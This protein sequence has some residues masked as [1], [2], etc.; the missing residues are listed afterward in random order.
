MKKKKTLLGLVLLVAVLMLGIGYAAVTADVLNIKGTANAGPDDANFV[1]AFDT[2]QEV[3]YE[4]SEGINANATVSGAYTDETN[5]TITVDK[6]TAKGEA[7]T[8]IYTVKNSSPDLKATLAATAEVDNTTYF[9]VEAV[10]TDTELAAGDSTTVKVTVTLDKT[11]ISDTEIA[12]PANV[13][14]KLTASP[15]AGA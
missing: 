9:K 4:K 13:T 6:L 2:E 7:V 11:P 5:A 8:A 15:A 12:K 1:V 3:T 10:P 14:V